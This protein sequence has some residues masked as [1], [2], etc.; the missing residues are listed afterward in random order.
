MVWEGSH[1]FV[2]KPFLDKSWDPHLGIVNVTLV[3]AS[4]VKAITTSLHS[5]S[6]LGRVI[7]EFL[8]K[9]FN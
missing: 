7:V 9:S 1:K 5:R 8:T 6:V 2:F 3:E 4:G